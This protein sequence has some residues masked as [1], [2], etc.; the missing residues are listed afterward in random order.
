M[1]FRMNK[2]IVLVEDHDDL[3]EVTAEWLAMAGFEVEPYATAELALARIEAGLPDVLITDLS[4]PGMGGAA[5][6]E[7]VRVL[8]GDRQLFIVALTGSSPASL[9]PSAAFDVV[10]TKPVDL[11]ALVARLRVGG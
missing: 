3:R 11:D 2:T 6:A 10:L 4:L 7:R 8:T 1:S 5:L 9:A